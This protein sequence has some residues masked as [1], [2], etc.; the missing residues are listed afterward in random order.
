MYHPACRAGSRVCHRRVG[1]GYFRR[2]HA[3]LVHG[4]HPW[5]WSVLLQLEDSATALLPDDLPLTPA[6]S[7]PV[8]M[9]TG[10]VHPGKPL[11]LTVLAGTSEALSKEG[12]VWKLYQGVSSARIL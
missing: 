10:R 1:T 12:A 11:L 8:P 6:P 9:T 7:P 2:T 3:R 5:R 4:D